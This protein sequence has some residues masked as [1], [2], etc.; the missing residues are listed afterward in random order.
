MTDII[1]NIKGT[2]EGSLLKENLNTNLSKTERVLS[3]A[4]GAYFTLKGIKNVF[5]SPL[6][7]ATGLALG[8]GLLNRGLSGHCSLTEE[9]EKES[10][11]PEPILVVKETVI[12]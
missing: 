8:Y 6:F 7:A 3:I 10:K 5:S 4:A 2:L 9:L 11:G 1:E 12:E